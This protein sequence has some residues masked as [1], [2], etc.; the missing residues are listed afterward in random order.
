MSEKNIEL[1]QAPE[2]YHLILS[3][4]LY[5]AI[6]FNQAYS[7]EKPKVSK[8]EA[9]EFE[10]F[11]K[12]FREFMGKIN[13]NDPS[14]FTLLSSIMGMW[15]YNRKYCGMCGRPI[16]GKPGH[17]Q[18]RMVCQTCDDSYK[19]AEELYK[20]EDFEEAQA[21]NRNATGYMPKNRSS[22]PVAPKGGTGE[23]DPRRKK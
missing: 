8:E 9:K 14:A 21:Y 1:V 13:E 18:N 5:K 22:K 4:S 7:N 17:I 23:V 11:K 10:K 2:P 20:R 19:I 3:H 16:I 6:K 12:L 15:G